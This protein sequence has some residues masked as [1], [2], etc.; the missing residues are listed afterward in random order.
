MTGATPGVRADGCPTGGA[1]VGF[2]GTVTSARMLLETVCSCGGRHVPPA[3]SDA[4]PGPVVVG[5]FASAGRLAQTWADPATG[6]L[7]R[8][9]LSQTR[10][11]YAVAD[12]PVPEGRLVR[13]STDLADLVGPGTAMWAA[14]VAATLAGDALPMPLTP[15]E[16]I[17]QLACGT[18]LGTPGGRERLTLD[19][20]D[21][22]DLADQARPITGRP[23]DPREVVRRALLHAVD[24][25]LAT[26]G[27][28]GV[29][30]DGGGLGAAALASVAPAPLRRLHVHL[31]VPVL[32]RRRGRLP[33]GT[34]VIDATAHWHQ[35]CDAS[36]CGS[37]GD[38]DP[39]PPAPDLLRS[40][41]WEAAPFLSGA[42][43]VRLLSGAT[44]APGR[45]R[46]GWRQLTMAAPFPTLFGRPGWRAWSP[47]R[48]DEPPPPHTDGDHADHADAALPGGW[49][50]SAVAQAG[51]AVTS[52]GA[53]SHLIPIVED[54]TGAVPGAE[55][56]Q[57]V[58]DLLERPPRTPGDRRL[59]PILVC[60][61]PVVLGAAVLLARHGRLR[62]RRR[63]GYVQRAPVLRDLVPSGL[64][65]ADVTPGA[66]ESLLAA[67]FVARRL[68]TPE[69]RAA[70]LAQVE[71]SP[72]ILPDRL[73]AVLAD[74]AR[75]LAE[76]RA[77][78]RLCATAALHPGAPAS[79]DRS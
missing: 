69:R 75:V 59:D 18:T 63:D 66:R 29:L 58:L 67:A 46:T 19:E 62:L 28:Y 16:G 17:F 77:L 33:A 78:Q 48:S 27:G 56:L 79:G 41:G 8:G 76:A 30:G 34:G 35:A 51:V 9:A 4:V 2:A 52:A 31:D 5:P 61:H 37:A 36:W 71:G 65:P 3:G 74:S 39:W 73:R 70:L 13:F 64:L 72:W 26:A 11:F 45:L 10:L 24:E 1:P 53:A 25:A 20:L 68:G 44:D 21:L 50:S 38:S 60:A 7:G 54:T 43:L 55:S 6:T 49:I 23:T 47:P 40:A 32:D 57:A 42:G 15:Y 22:A 14:A 12:G